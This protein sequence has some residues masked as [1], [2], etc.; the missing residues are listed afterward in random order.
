MASTDRTSILK[1]TLRERVKQYI[2]YDGSG[3]ATDIYEVHADAR[4]GDPCLRTR[5]SFD[6]ATNRVVKR[7]ETEDVWSS[8]YDYP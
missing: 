7:Y 8:S 1:T 2:V 4:D 3:R 5:Y 6:G